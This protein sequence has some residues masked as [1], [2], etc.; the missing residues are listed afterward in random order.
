[1]LFLIPSDSVCHLIRKNDK[2]TTVAREKSGFNKRNLMS[3]QEELI[4]QFTGRLDLLSPSQIDS[5]EV[6]VDAYKGFWQHIR[7]RKGWA[8]VRQVVCI[9][10]W[11]RQPFFS[12]KEVLPLLYEAAEIVFRIRN[13]FD[14]LQQKITLRQVEGNAKE[15]LFQLSEEKI[16]PTDH[17]DFVKE[18]VKA[19]LKVLI[20]LGRILTLEGK[21][22][23]FIQSD[24]R[25]NRFVFWIMQT[26][27]GTTND[28]KG[29]T[30]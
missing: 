5:V 24:D 1:M 8:T 10:N 22:I 7:F 21:W 28:R 16:K 20:D 12:C 2:I 4:L 27:Y 6:I 29:L 30:L 19:T 15:Y 23:L 25:T 9:S 26:I 14:S 13:L 3:T 18:L 11:S 17:P